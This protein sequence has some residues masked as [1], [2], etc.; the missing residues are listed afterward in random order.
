MSLARLSA[1]NGYRY[2]LRHTACGDACRQPGTDLTAYYAASGYPPGQWLGKGLA[3]LD[4]GR[5]LAVGTA[6]IEEAMAALYGSGRDPVNGQPLGRPYLTG[7]AA[8]Q[9][10]GPPHAAAGGCS[11]ATATVSVGRPTAVEADNKAAGR[12]RAGRAAVAGF[13][14]TFTVPKSASVLWALGDRTVQAAVLGA[15]REA[16]AAALGLVEDRFLHT[17][18]GHGGC[19][20]LPTR[21]MIAATFDHWDTRTGDPN[22]HTHV[23][24]ANR[25]QGPDGAWRSLDSRALHQAAVAVSEVYDDLIA[26]AISARL[27][28]RWSWRARGERRSPAFEID[29]LDDH[30]LAVFSSR[31]GQIAAAMREVIGQFRARHDRDP[32]RRE[33][34]RLRQQATLATRPDKTVRSL[35]EL[36]GRWRDTTT[37]L[38]GAAPE[39]LIARV[40][41]ARPAPA[42]EP[43][44]AALAAAVL[45]GVGERRPTW[46]RA[47]LLAEAA[48]ATRH[49]RTGAPAERLA[50]LDRVVDAGLARCVALDPPELFE[51]PYRF[52]RADGTSVF[53]RPDEHA[54]TTTAVLEAEDRLVAATAETGAP[55]LDPKVLAPVLAA[56]AIGMPGARGLTGDQIGA[57]DA[58]ASSGRLVDVLVG[59]AGSGKTRALRAL[60]SA[61]DNAHGAGS[62][63]G[64]AASAVAAVELGASLRIGC[65]NTAK[66]LHE[67]G[68]EYPDPRWVMRSGQL[69]IVDE[70][71]MVTTDHLDRLVAQARAAGAKVLLVG[72]DQQLGAVGAGGAF[73]LLTET[74]NT[75]HLHGL[76]RF[77]RRWE[78]DATRGLRDGRAAALD[79][80]AAHGRVHD[81]PG[82]LMLDAA[83]TAWANDVAAGRAALLLAADRASVTALNARAHD[84]RVSAGLAHD[85]G[86]VL[87]D[88]NTAGRGDVVVTRRNNR[89]LKLDGT[90]A[91]VRNGALWRITDVH[92]DGAID[93]T[94][95]DGTGRVRLP[96]GYVREHVELGYAA[97]V[98]RAQGMTVDA[99]HV[100]TS[101][102]MT[103]QTLYV[104]MTRGREANHA[105][106]ATDGIDPAC[107]DPAVP[108]AATGPEVLRTVLANDG[109]ERSATATLRQRQ[110]TSTS[111]RRLLPIRDLLRRA[112]TDPE[113]AAAVERIDG[114]VRERVAE[115]R[116]G[117]PARH[118]AANRPIQEGI[119][120]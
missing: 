61:W 39:T 19:A 100:L 113:A 101:T 47:N 24:I 20:Q 64:L 120:R 38:T 83:Y 10:T 99:A 107:P 118:Q 92:P 15:H 77:R 104:A 58:I 14:L 6:V 94:P 89:S 31:S 7:S 66:W 33:V 17:R 90:D 88:D 5:G 11:E 74:P 110:D 23:V 109:A 70:A 87:A 53:T 59:P 79:A 54:F 111:L 72:D 9:P 116:A 91:H 78:A 35:G 44:L 95:V 71:S 93:V 69:V 80:Y 3:G 56:A 48:R 22:L 2:L 86:I 63:L 49:L 29:G 76:W 117:M 42:V 28:V 16:V 52:R 119:R 34:L 84:E 65:E 30:L 36:I 68:R 27:P 82:E 18:V 40:L 103:R 112:E 50:L 98:H 97:T 37:T 26:D 46:T 45:M 1:G 102:L 41:R 57:V 114:I 96:A 108:V 62:V 8:D 60:R 25:V 105:W 55:A 21:G 51:V 67:T 73:G 43:D 85:D 81:G 106:V 4:A 75:A 32:N 115:R 12:G 13:D